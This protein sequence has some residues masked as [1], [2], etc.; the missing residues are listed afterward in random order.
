M[1]GSVISNQIRDKIETLNVDDK[2]VI[3]LK[4]IPISVVDPAKSRIV[5]SGG[6]S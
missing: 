1:S 4:G 3:V 6:N 2:S 5:L